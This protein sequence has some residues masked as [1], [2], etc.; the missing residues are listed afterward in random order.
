MFLRIV[1]HHLQGLT[2]QRM[3]SDALLLM[4]AAVIVPAVVFKAPM[5]QTLASGCL[6]AGGVLLVNNVS[7]F[8]GRLY[9]RPFSQTFARGVLAT[10][11]AM[12]VAWLAMAWLPYGWTPDPLQGG[13]LKSSGVDPGRFQS[14]L[15]QL[16]AMST[17]AALMLWRSA[18]THRAGM[19][20]AAAT[21]AVPG[22]RVL[23]LGTGVVAHRVVDILQKA[24]SP[25]QIVGHVV[26]P[27]EPD[28][29]PAGLQ[30]LPA[31]GSLSALAEAHQVQEVLVALTERRGGATPL[32]ELLDCKIRGPAVN[33]V[34]THF[35][36]NLGQI[37]LEHLS[38]HWLIFGD[39]FNQGTART[40][41]KRLFDLVFVAL[42]I[43]P[44][45]VLMALAALAIKLESPGP[46]LYRQER[47]GL[48]GRLFS[49]TKLRSM[50]V[51]A[52]GDGRP[53]WARDN[54]ERITR[55]GRFIRASRIDELPQLFNVLRGEMSLVG[56]RPERPFFVDQ[57]TREIP[58]YAV[59]HCV[60]PGLTGW[61]QV[62]CDYGSSVDEARNKLQYDLFYVK[63]HS[64]FL[65]ILI[66]L[67]TV[68]VV[69]TGKGAR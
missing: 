38:A 7:G 31:S 40:L 10:S 58:F 14:D 54:D 59:R 68:G 48:G 32:R 34:N 18:S 19:E 2:L 49:V 44:G 20:T 41:I 4:L 65:D 36:R 56:P 22:R 60:K 61:A 28:S 53:R 45:L 6:L 39:G 33:D 52:E 26:G 27:V 51:D 64:L 8:Y 42:L 67:E 66:A 9:S 50:R 62:R 47:I 5:A 30:I 12:G 16:Y 1:Q 46:V 43:G 15:L 13:L 37:R 17:T 25:A 63:N 35:E 21:P 69:L 55:V 24:G 29:Q 23:I 3:L 11:A 57:L